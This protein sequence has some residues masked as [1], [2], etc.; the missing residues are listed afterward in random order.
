[1]AKKI[2]VTIIVGALLALFAW[3][4]WPTIDKKP[5]FNHPVQLSDHIQV[6]FE[7][8]PKYET[9][10][11]DGI[12]SE[13]Y[14]AYR[15][16]MSAMVQGLTFPEDQMGTPVALER[17]KIFEQDVAAFE[18]EVLVDEKVMMPFVGQRYVLENYNVDGTPAKQMEVFLYQTENYLFK[19]AAVWE[20]DDP[21][22]AE[23]AQM[24]FRKFIPICTFD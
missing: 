13:V 7:K 6:S 21:K 18:G 3:R 17:Q 19:I 10:E 4:N 23:R 1:M 15:R 2:I 8:A 9:A 22:A 20:A 14:Y 5:E 12:T 11:R 16:G 24:Y